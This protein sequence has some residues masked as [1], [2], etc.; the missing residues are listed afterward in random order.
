M[1]KQK[2]INPIRIWS[3][4]ILELTTPLKI[5]SGNKDF[6]S[7]SLLVKDVNGLPFIPASSIAGILRHALEEETANDLFGC[8]TVNDGWGSS[9]LLT[10]GH[11]LNRDGTVLD[12]I[13]GTDEINDFVLRFMR[14]P[15]RQHVCINEKGVSERG[16]KYD[17]EI[18]YKG[19]RFCFEM[20]LLQ[21]E[22]HTKSMQQLVS[23]LTNKSTRIGGGSRKGFGGFSVISA[24]MRVFDLEKEEDLSVYLKKS[25]SLNYPLPSG[26]FDALK[27]EQVVPPKLYTTYRL[28]LEP[29][30]TVLFGAGFG[31]SEADVISVE[32]DVV[33]WDA[34]GRGSF[35]DKQLLIPA[36][37]VKGALAHRVAYHYNRIKGIYADKLSVEDYI[38]YVG[39]N[40]PAVNAL[41]GSEIKGVQKRGNTLF[42]D[43]FIDASGEQSKTF[44]NHISIDRFTGGAMP[45]VL[46]TEQVDYLNG[47][48]L[49]MEIQVANTIDEEVLSAFE[50]ALNDLCSER[51]PLGGAVNRGHGIFKGSYSKIN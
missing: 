38:Q 49:T 43:V 27:I 5:A 34:N 3:K 9:V 16:G 51:L 22:G 11:L 42:S 29:N 25:S 12:G 4:F 13:L 19:A 50:Y 8:Q 47:C 39:S 36:S 14:L 35:Q 45:G 10:S 30:D 46:F 33:T 44:L 31:S 28:T 21:N 18:L 23:I 37:S 41:F 26:S 6:L 32:E 15:I 48:I 40:N 7:D 20:E 17:E 1:T 24:Y 2:T